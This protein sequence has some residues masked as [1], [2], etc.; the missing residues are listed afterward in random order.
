MHCRVR[1]FAGVCG[2]IDCCDDYYD[3]YDADRGDYYDYKAHD[4]KDYC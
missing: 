1:D 4:L 3:Y 2:Y